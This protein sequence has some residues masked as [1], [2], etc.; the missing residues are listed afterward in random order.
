MQVKKA[1]FIGIGG[2]GMSATAK[3]LKDNGV[4]VSG[5]DET[6]YPPISTFL[7]AQGLPYKTPY[8][9][10]NIPGDC[11]LIVI[12]KNAKLVPETNPEV[13]AAFLSGKKIMSFPEVLGELS[14]GQEAVVVAGSYGKSTTT[15]LLA[16]CLLEAEKDPSFFIGASPYTPYTS[17][18]RGKGPLFIFEGDEYPASN[19]DARSKFLLLHPAHLLITP[20]AHDH[21]NVFPTIADYLKPFSELVALLPKEGTLVVCSEGALSADFIRSLSREPLTYGLKEGD[22]QAGNIEWGEHTSFDILERGKV[23]IRLETTLLGEHNIQNIVGA[24]AFL[25]SQKYMTPEEFALGVRTFR[26]IERRLDKKTELSN[27]P[28]FEG[29]GSS[30]EKL[31]S[32]ID[33]MKKHFPQ[34]RLVVVFEPNTITWRSRAALAQ[35]DT[36]FAG[37]QRVY[38]YNPPHDGKGTELTL[39]EIVAQVNLAGVRATGVADAETTLAELTKELQENDVVLISSSGAMGGLTQS[40]PQLAEKLFPKTI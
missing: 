26:G 2:V 10:E 19:T 17:A 16:H 4:I 3:L 7:L 20:L 15:A 8:A 38:V 14:V 6:V 9:P 37:A 34:R 27:V 1:H 28:V 12:G 22:W 11:D 40:I 21:I 5:S 18:A 23:V 25:L 36:A 24:G 35:Y 31:R 39:E 33:A 13:A 29:F 30:H 32:A